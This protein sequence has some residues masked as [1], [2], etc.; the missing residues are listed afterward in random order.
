VGSD[1]EQ[2]V[3]EE[4]TWPKTEHGGVMYNTCELGGVVEKGERLGVLKDTA[5][6]ALEE[7]YAPYRSVILDTRYQPTVFPGD[8]TFHCGKID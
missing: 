1:V 8:W 6:R 5:G 4:S 3:A 2:L 7:V